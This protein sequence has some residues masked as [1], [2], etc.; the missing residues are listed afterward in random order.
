MKIVN[1][2]PLAAAT[3]A[4]ATPLLPLV[5]HTNVEP[6]EINPCFWRFQQ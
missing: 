1:R 6:A 2:W 3:I 5:A 4:K